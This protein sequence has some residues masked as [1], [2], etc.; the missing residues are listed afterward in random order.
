MEETKLIL[1]RK[2]LG[3]GWES[4]YEEIWINVA[5]IEHL[6]KTSDSDDTLITMMN[7]TTHNVVET[8]E[9]IQAK[10]AA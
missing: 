7:K 5:Q 1:L 2:E 8:P 4:K 6:K 10:I 3:E 9:E